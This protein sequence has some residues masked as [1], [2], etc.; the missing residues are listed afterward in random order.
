ME[1]LISFTCTYC[2][3]DFT[4]Q[5]YFG[6]PRIYTSEDPLAMQEYYTA[7]TVAKA[8]CPYCGTVNE[9]LCE[10]EIFHKDIVDLAIRRYKRG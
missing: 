2:Q 5:P 1:R 7:Q 3:Q 6:T 8:V 9:L 4:I 10:N